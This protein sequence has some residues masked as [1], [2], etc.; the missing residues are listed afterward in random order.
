M[1]M[2]V[3]TWWMICSLKS[4]ARGRKGARG[5]Y[6]SLAATP[7]APPPSRLQN[8]APTS[9]QALPDTH[10]EG[11]ENPAETSPRLPPPSPES[12]VA[13]A[14]LPLDVGGDAEEQRPVE[15]EF[16]HV[17]PVLGGQHALKAKRRAGGA[18]PPSPGGVPSPSVGTS[19]THGCPGDPSAPHGVQTPFPGRQRRC[20]NPGETPPA[21]PGGSASRPGWRRGGRR[22]RGRAAGR[23]LTWMGYPFHT[24]RRS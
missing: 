19:Q 9:S 12:P 18:P 16:D 5:G 14:H 17:V 11:E 1:R 2:M 6:R 4:C 3:A 15:G 7:S 20:A 23:A 8:L 21:P 22:G 10:H 24:S 13:A